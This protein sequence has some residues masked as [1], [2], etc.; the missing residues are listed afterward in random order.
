MTLDECKKVFERVSEGAV[1]DCIDKES[2]FEIY[3]EKEEM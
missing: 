2:Y 3:K 1:F